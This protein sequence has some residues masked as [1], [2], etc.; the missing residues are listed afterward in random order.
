MSSVL[1]ATKEID[2]A[3]KLRQQLSRYGFTGLTAAVYERLI[4]RIIKEAPRIVILEMNGA[5]SRD[6]LHEL[7][8]STRVKR[9]IPIL[10]LA[11]VDSLSNPDD[12]LAMNDFLMPPYNVEEMAVRAKRLLHEVEKPEEILQSGD[13]EI[14]LANCEVRVMGKI[15]ELT[16][17][18]YE[19]LKFMASDPGR[20]FTRETLLDKVW[21]YDYFGGDRTVDVHVRRLRSKIEFSEKTFI[22]TVRNIGYRFKKA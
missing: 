15:I 20:V 1:I 11:D 13:L 10:A 7:A 4:E 21:G 3:K 6:I 14:D 9:K 17:K 16:F 2:T 22:D 12:Y 18:E 19:L 5:E 8:N